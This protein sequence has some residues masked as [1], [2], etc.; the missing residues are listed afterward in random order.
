MGLVRSYNAGGGATS[1]DRVLCE[2]Q[3]MAILYPI[4]W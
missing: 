2:L 4:F 3:A 1:R